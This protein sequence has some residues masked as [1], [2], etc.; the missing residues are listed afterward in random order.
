MKYYCV[1]DTNVLVSSMLKE[2]SIPGEIIKLIEDGIISPLLNDAIIK[3]YEDV[4]NRNKFGFSALQIAK[5][6]S[7]IKQKGF[8][9]FQT[10]TEENFIDNEDAVFYEIALTGKAFLDAYLVTGNIKHFPKKHFVVTPREMLE[11]IEKDRLIN[12]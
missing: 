12:K 10:Y 5:K 8:Y 6:L 7:L 4:I 2:D 3:E 9:L 1:I 11:I